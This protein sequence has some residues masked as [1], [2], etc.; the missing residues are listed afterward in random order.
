MDMKNELNALELSKT[1]ELV[2][3]PKNKQTIGYNW[4]FRIKY[5]YDGTIE[6][7]KARLVAK[8]YN[9]QEVLDFCDTFSPVAKI[10]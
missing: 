7:H 3:L 1:C 9:Q 10:T 8:G 6:R 4:I 2:T 5:K